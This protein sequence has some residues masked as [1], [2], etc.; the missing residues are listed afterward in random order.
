MIDELPGR[1]TYT[2]IVLA[3]SALLLANVRFGAWGV[4]R[5][6]LVIHVVGE[7]FSD[8]FWSSIP[9]Y[10]FL[11]NVGELDRVRG[12][13][14]LLGAIAI[15]DLAYRVV[16]AACGVVVRN[17]SRLGHATHHAL[18]DAVDRNESGP[19]R[20]GL[21]AVVFLAGMGCKLLF[22]AAAGVLGGGTSLTELRPEDSVGLGAV[23]AIGDFLVPVGLALR[24][25]GRSRAVLPDLL[26]LALLAFASFSKAAFISS[27]LTYATVLVLQRGWSYVRA[28]LVNWRLALVLALAVANLGV[29]SLQRAEAGAAASAG[30]IASAAVG[31]SSARFLGGIHRTYF[32]VAREIV[33]NGAPGMHGTYHAQIAYLWVPR[34]LWP[35]KPRV[36]AEQLFYLLG[37]TEEAY[38]TAFAANVFGFLLLD[39]G[40]VGLWFGS[41]ALGSALAFGDRTVPSLRGGQGMLVAGPLGIVWRTVWV[42]AGIP[43][44]EGG[45]PMAIIHVVLL[46]TAFAGVYAVYVVARSILA[47]AGDLPTES[48]TSTGTHLVF[49]KR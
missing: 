35:D 8:P 4:L 43:L 30:D 17:A 16:R 3:T 28:S 11:R 27:L 5:G 10:A 24:H 9:T 36:A 40:L 1:F 19:H 15:A 46:G 33:A 34:V 2:I 44:S 45:I 47:A 12:G 23:V 42:T 29:K 7:F 48:S 22:L 25:R 39:F 26:V 38:G 31:G 18:A 41:A 37:V 13:L 20:A 21:G 6:I 32:V 14:L 49:P